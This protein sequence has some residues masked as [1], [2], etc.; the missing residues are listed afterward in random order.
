M[1]TEAERRQ[2]DRQT[3]EKALKASNG[4]V[5]GPGGAAEL[6]GIK[7]LLA[8]KPFGLSGGEKQR[9]ALGRALI[10][11]PDLVRRMAAGE[12]SESACDHC[13]LCMAR[14]GFEPTRCVLREP[15]PLTPKGS[16]SQSP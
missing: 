12:V 9:I 7:P 2:R 15:L 16:P 3:I 5:F 11:R 6:L 1:L 4:K 14:V 13:N 10:R 8:R